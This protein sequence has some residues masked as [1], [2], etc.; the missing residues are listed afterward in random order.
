M[1]PAHFFPFISPIG[2]QQKNLQ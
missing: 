2:I 1:V